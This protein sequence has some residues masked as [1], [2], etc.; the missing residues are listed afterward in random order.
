LKEQCGSELHAFQFG[1]PLTKF[2]NPSLPSK[3]LWKLLENDGAAE[4]ELHAGAILF[5][6]EELNAYYSMDAVVDLPP[7]VSNN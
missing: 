2:L 3:I 7:E 4:D 5:S 1:K 6:P